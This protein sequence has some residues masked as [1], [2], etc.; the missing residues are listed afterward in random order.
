MKLLL[1]FVLFCA[2]SASLGQK[3]KKDLTEENMVDGLGTL[4]QHQLDF[5][6][7]K[8]DW[9]RTVVFKGNWSD[10]MTEINGR[11]SGI[12]FRV[13]AA[14]AAQF[15]LE[16]GLSSR[17][18][19]VQER[20]LL[21]E[22]LLE[23][24]AESRVEAVGKLQKTLL[25]IS[26]SLRQLESFLHRADGARVNSTVALGKSLE[27]IQG[28]LNT[29]DSHLEGREW[30]TTPM[31]SQGPNT[32]LGKLKLSWGE[33]WEPSLAILAIG[34]I[35]GG[36]LSSCLACCLCCKCCRGQKVVPNPA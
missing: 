34:L 9:N 27:V 32:F 17:L 3:T 2:V 4:L 25:E 10:A 20:L 19:L 33:N 23:E 11:L 14:E 35:F 36:L 26:R 1:L 13:A 29:V 18:G 28:T 7:F 31:E 6:T 5:E 12:E 22:E 16:K 30:I 15:R 24:A 21:L 8:Q